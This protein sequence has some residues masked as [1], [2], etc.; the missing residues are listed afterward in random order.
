MFGSIAGA[1][2]VLLAFDED[3]ETAG[4]DGRGAARHRAGAAGQGRRQ[5]D[6]DDPRL[7]RGAALRGRARATPGAER[8][9]RAIYESVLEATAAGVQTPDLG[10]HATTTEFTDATSSSACARRSTSGPRSGTARLSALGAALAR[11]RVAAARRFRPTPRPRFT[12]TCSPLPRTPGRPRPHGARPSGAPSTWPSPSP[13]SRA[14]PPLATSGPAARCGLRER[15]PAR[16]RRLRHAPSAPRAP[17][18]AGAAR[19]RRDGPRA[20]PCCVTPTGRLRGTAARIASRA[21]RPG[22]AATNDPG[23]P[24]ERPAVVQRPARP[25]APGASYS[26][27]GSPRRPR[28]GVGHA[29]LPHTRI[30]PDRRAAWASTRASPAREGVASSAARPRSRSPGPSVRAQPVAELALAGRLAAPGLEPAR[31]DRS[32]LDGARKP[33]CPTSVA[34]TRAVPPVAGQVLAERSIAARTAP[35]VASASADGA[36]D[37]PRSSA[38]RRTARDAARVRQAHN[39]RTSRPRGGPFKI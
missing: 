29:D 5:P 12:N 10:G 31:S 19:A 16:S 15:E 2:S 3:Y 34:R 7:R 22:R 24:W 1:E 39:A 11:L 18:R 28:A 9:S 37:R 25:T 38:R 23:R 6:G 20:D 36:R 27:P 4:R 33:G 17:E 8:A 21:D 30:E 35:S 13:R 14:A 32:P 26:A